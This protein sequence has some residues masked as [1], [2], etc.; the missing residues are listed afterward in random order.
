[1]SSIGPIVFVIALALPFLDAWHF[2]SFGVH[3]DHWRTEKVAA[4]P[5]NALVVTDPSLTRIRLERSR[6]AADAF[7]CCC[8]CLSQGGTDA[9]LDCGLRRWPEVGFGDIGADL[10]E[11]CFWIVP[12]LPTTYRGPT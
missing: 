9:I 7:A 2:A 12:G 4:I 6:L 8:F 1:M 11:A 10:R 3:E 5:T